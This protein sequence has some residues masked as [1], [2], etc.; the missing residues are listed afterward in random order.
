[1]KMGR[2]EIVAPVRDAVAELE[3]EQLGRVGEAGD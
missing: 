2:G 1:M 3:Y